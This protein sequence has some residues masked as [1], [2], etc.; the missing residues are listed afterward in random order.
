M[1]TQTN[2]YGLSRKDLT[3][4]M[5]RDIRKRC[6]FGCV[7]CGNALYQYHHFD[8]PFENAKAH[9]V[10]NI[11]LLCPNCHQLVG[12]GWRSDSTFK[13]WTKNPVCFQNNYSHLNIEI[14]EQTPTIVFGNATFVGNQFPIRASSGEPIIEIEAPE[15]ESA[16]YTINAVFQDRMGNE[17]ARI[18]HNEWQGLS[19]NWDIQAKK[20]RIVVHSARR[21]ID[22]ILQTVPPNNLVI[23]RLYMYYKGF[24]LTCNRNGAMSIYGPDNKKQP[25][26]ILD[27]ATILDNS[28]GIIL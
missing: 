3:E 4:T 11:A 21:K 20:G 17:I 7:H 2:R 28:N 13:K 1:T 5:K 18:V 16:P 8:P 25:M 10:E 15:A 6:G 23:E 12:D 14:G 26:W 24:Q 27:G 19:R 22:L 9:L